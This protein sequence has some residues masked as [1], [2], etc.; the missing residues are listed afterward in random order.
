MSSLGDRGDVSQSNDASANAGAANLN[1]WGQDIDQSQGGGGG[2][3]V[4]GEANDS[5]QSAS[6][7]ALAAEEYPSNTDVGIRVLS[8]GHG[9]DVEQ[10]NS[11]DADERLR[12]AT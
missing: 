5:D 10:S 9:G 3:Q 12:T 1:G 4:A 2:T 7:G 11:A 6:A 8:P